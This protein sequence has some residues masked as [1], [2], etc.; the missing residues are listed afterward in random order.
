MLKGLTLIVSVVGAFSWL[1]CE[2]PRGPIGVPGEGGPPGARGETGPRGEMGVEGERG[3]RGPSGESPQLPEPL[4]LEVNGLVGMVTDP[5]GSV[6]GGRVYLVPA[7]DVDALSRNPIDLTLSP[8]ATA[9]VAHDEPLED[10]LDRRAADY[11]SAAVDA[12]GHYR[13]RTLDEGG[14]FVVWAPAPD[15]AQHLPG[16]SACRSALQRASLVGR[17]LDLRVSGAASDRASH[18]GSTSCLGCHGRHRSLRSAH[19]V[20]LQVPGRRGALQDISPWPNFD[21]A[22][23]AFSQRLTLYYYDCDAARAGTAKCRVSATDPSLTAGG[24]AVQFELRLARAGAMSGGYELQFVNRAGSGAKTFSLDLSYG[25]ALMRQVYLT[26]MALPGGGT[27]HFVLPL[28]VNLEGLPGAPS[29]DDW[30][31][32]DYRSDDWYNFANASLLDPSPS[33]AFDN[34]CAGCHFTG[35]Q[36]RGDASAGFRASAVSDVNADYDFDADGRA[37]EINTGCE[38]CHGPGSEHI[39]SSV[40]GRHIVSPSLL[41]PERE[42]MLCGSCHSR[43]AGHA[44]GRTETPLSEQGRMPLPGLRRATFAKQFTTRVDASAADLFPSGDSRANH[45]QYGDF[46]RSRM[47]RNPQVLMTC[48]SCHDAHGS[49]SAPHML[50]T[51]ADDN[52]A[53]TGCHSESFYTSPLEH[54]AKATGEK[55]LGVEEQEFLCTRCHMVRTAAGGARHPELLDALPRAATPV[56]YFHGDLASHRFTVTRRS[57]AALQPVAATLSCAFCHG[58][59]FP[60]P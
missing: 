21:A 7:S 34:N 5:S 58:T 29:S 31:Y 45:Q 1:A 57:E 42:L 24:P 40:R 23:Q 43:P 28:Q 49:D 6:A 27:A 25:G 38:A 16:G 18:V 2:G 12:S 19:R 48:S 37:D 47:H 30:S 54:V 44:G 14:Y 32:R 26:R 52:A 13:F 9:E 3:E 55:H 50:R 20:G 46:L 17:R 11:Q 56:Q 36:L 22:L 10:L 15:D 53:C 59:Q 51:A 33:R 35:M 60:N 4:P 8:E 39:E 41:T